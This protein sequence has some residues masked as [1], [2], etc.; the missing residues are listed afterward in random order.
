M[1]S[2]R[3]V[4]ASLYGTWRLARFDRAAIGYF[5]ATLQGF[6]RS[7]FAAVLAAPADFA[8]QL[9]FRPAP[10]PDDVFR[11]GLGLLVVYVFSWLIWP[12]AAIYLARVLDRDD[13]LLLYLTAHNWA[14]VPA[15]LFQLAVL[16]L[17]LGLLPPAMVT[18]ALLLSVVA[19]LVYE[20]FIASIA[21]RIDRLA[22]AGVVIA[23]FVILVLVSSI[24]ASLTS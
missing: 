24:G 15:V 23:Y 4:V 2:L 12:L 11:Y 10:L 8:I 21:L 16:I 3:E 1:I 13:A 6:W 22:A 9:L 20:W 5:D 19:V 14:Q 7:F 17:A 18:L